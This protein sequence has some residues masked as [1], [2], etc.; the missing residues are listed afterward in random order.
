MT[1][2]DTAKVVQL[3]WLQSLNV[4][5]TC[6]IGPL[7]LLGMPNSPENWP[8]ATWMPTPVRK[9]ISTVRERKSAR[10]PRRR[11]RARSRNAADDECGHAGE[12][13]I[14][15]RRYGRQPA[16]AGEH[17]RRR[18]RVGAD[19]EVPRGPEEGEQDD[20]QDDRVEA[21]DDRHAG[22]GGVAHH[23]RDGEARQRDAGDDLHRESLL[24]EGPH[25]LEQL[26][27]EAPPCCLLGLGGDVRA[28]FAHGDLRR[29]IAGPLL[30]RG[31]DG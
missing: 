31:V 3:T 19:H 15:R 14:G 10:K 1:E 12:G 7:P 2:I 16:E 23:L 22:D 30:P 26:D 4:L 28:G 21:G 9:P 17:D 5:T 18:R 24:L 6:S 11:M 27:R 25:A 13:D 29:L 8:Q 20:G